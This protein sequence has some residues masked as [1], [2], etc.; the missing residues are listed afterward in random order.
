MKDYAVTRPRQAWEYKP[1]LVQFMR[2]T[3]S[4]GSAFPTTNTNSLSLNPP[5]SLPSTAQM[6][7]G[8]SVAESLVHLVS[9]KKKNPPRADKEGEGWT[10]HSTYL[11]W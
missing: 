9:K 1:Q 6:V 7:P 2:P 8:L 11:F 3:S 4:Q 10:L 5:H